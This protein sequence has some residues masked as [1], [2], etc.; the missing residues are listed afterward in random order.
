MTFSPT[1]LEI[2]V[3]GGIGLIGLSVLSLLSLWAYER[4]KGT[5]W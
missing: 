5:L 4:K 2:V 3:T 1:F